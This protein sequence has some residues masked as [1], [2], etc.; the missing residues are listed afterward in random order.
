MPELVA[1]TE[2]LHVAWL[3]A[4][5]EWGP[6]LHEDGFGLRPSDEVASAEGFAAWIADLAKRSDPASPEVGQ[7]QVFF[8]WLVD[9]V[10]VLGGVALRVG[11]DDYVQWAGHVGFGLRP[12]ARGRGLG[13]WVLR[14]ALDQARALG[15]Q[16]VLAV[17]AVDN[18]ASVKTIERCGGVL[19]GV[20]PTPHGPARRYWIPT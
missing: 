2:R 10:R 1:P 7:P 6:G 3:E 20:R 8:R 16:R 5:A 12:S 17:C 4:H 19:E 9:N 11:D 18:A 13:T 14:S 15:R